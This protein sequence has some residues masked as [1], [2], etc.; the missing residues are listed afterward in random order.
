MIF[1]VA[2]LI[3]PKAGTWLW[4]HAGPDVLWT[5]CLGLSVIV[6][7]GLA[8]TGPARRRRMAHM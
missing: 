6:A 7:I 8:L 1:G 3:G 4:Q 2:Q 5:S